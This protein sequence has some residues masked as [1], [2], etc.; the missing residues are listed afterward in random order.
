MPLLTGAGG[1]RLGDDGG[2]GGGGGPYSQTI[3]K[4]GMLVSILLTALLACF[5]IVPV[6]SLGVVSFLGSVQEAPL[7]NG[8]HLINPLSSVILMST[9]LK[10]LHFAD[11]V[12]T[13]E[14]VNVHLAA[15]CINRIDPKMAVELYRSVGNNFEEKILLPE[16]QSVVRAVTSA[17]SSQA[18]YSAEARLAMS[19]DLLQ[20]ID[21]LVKGRGIIVEIALIN[22]LLL[23]ATIEVAIEKKMAMEQ[24]AEQM[25]YILQKERLLAD[26]KVILAEG[27]AKFQNIVSS[28]ITPRLL[29][30]K[31]IEVTKSLAQNCNPKVVV[32]G[33]SGD[34]GG[35]PLILNPPSERP[36][37]LNTLKAMDKNIHNNNIMS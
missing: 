14:G 21:K 10:V 23:P 30:W 27:I 15:S 24:Q 6:G 17:H 13:Q 1:R 31:G 4:A 29:E 5:T 33:G 19:R 25:K 34:A 35:I 7:P 2:G 9:R 22:R 36:Q 11:N 32:I 3:I 8:W 37:A 28:G 18:L 26:Q 20:G 12:P 16:F